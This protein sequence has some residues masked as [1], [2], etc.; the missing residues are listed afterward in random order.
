MATLCKAK[1]NSSIRLQGK[2]LLTI[3]TY[4]ERLWQ[5]HHLQTISDEGMLPYFQLAALLYVAIL[6]KHTF[7]QR[8]A[9]APPHCLSTH[10]VWRMPHRDTL[11]ALASAPTA[12]T[13]ESIGSDAATVAVLS[14]AALHPPHVL[15]H[16]LTAQRSSVHASPTI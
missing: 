5:D 13:R 2:R 15:G 8:S 10:P 6:I 7:R 11:T 1:F 3:G 16:R 9:C 14:L 4:E 12:G